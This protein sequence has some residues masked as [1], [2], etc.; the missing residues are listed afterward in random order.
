ML[1]EFPDWDPSTMPSPAV[2]AQT[3]KEWRD[4]GFFYDRDD[5]GRRWRL[6]GSKAGLAGFCQLLRRYVANPT[7]GQLSEHD[8]YGPYMYLKVMTW[9]EANVDSN[10]IAGR[11]E[12]LSRLST[13]LEARLAAASPGQSFEIGREYAPASDYA[14]EVQIAD[15]G[16]DPASADPYCADQPSP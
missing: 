10:A 13:M 8:H 14:L 6:V 1:A 2:N 4:L 16:F 9:T 15:D 11:L 5:T 3:R 12:D 7:N